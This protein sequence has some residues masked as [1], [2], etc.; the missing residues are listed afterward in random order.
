MTAL[1][2]FSSDPISMV[3]P[4]GKP[5]PAYVHRGP[6]R[7]VTPAEEVIAD[8]AAESVKHGIENLERHFLDEAIFEFETA[9]SV[10]P[11]F[12][13]AHWMRGQALLMKGD[14]LEGFKEF[15]WRFKMFSDALCHKG[16]PIW[17]GEPLSGKSLLLWHEHGYGDSIMFLR[18][19][20][21]L[22][23]MGARITLAL[24]E[25]L[26]RLAREQF[27]VEVL[28]EVPLSFNHFDYRCPI[29]SLPPVLCKSVAD[30]PSE[31]YFA[32]NAYRA[33]IPRDKPIIGIAW[34]GNRNNSRDKHRS[35]KLEK[36][37]TAL[38]TRGHALYAIQQDELSIGRAHG[39]IAPTF[40]DFAETAD[41]LMA[42]DHIVTVDTAVA[43]LAGALGHPSL[44]IL[45]PFVAFWPWYQS[46]AWY[47]TAHVYR[48]SKPGEWAPVFAKVNE[49]LNA[50]S[51]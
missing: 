36:F 45:V 26:R 4:S 32:A 49:A 39:V 43:H 2:E 6:C 51:H 48:Q 40:A 12:P 31:P 3:L 28:D 33:T 15:D 25:P 14:Y 44:H 38:D 1:R 20:P 42:M 24:P 27:D 16:I 29:F 11:E 13:H 46:Q 9:I 21:M 22:K 18:Y 5:N 23:R 30:L 7:P 17:S 41:C 35:I 47:P 10:L 8:V 34:S 19:V 50:K 37:L